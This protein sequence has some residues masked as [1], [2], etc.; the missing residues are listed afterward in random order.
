[1]IDMS[2]RINKKD[3]LKED[4]N[5]L[6]SLLLVKTN[7]LLFKYEIIHQIFWND[8]CS[9]SKVIDKTMTKSGANKKFRKI[10]KQILS[11]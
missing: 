7:A 5:T 6:H 11:Y 10:S 3:Y 1:M 2:S 8:N 4:G 9:T